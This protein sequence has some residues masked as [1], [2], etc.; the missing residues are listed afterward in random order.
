MTEKVPSLSSGR[1]T[2]TNKWVPKPKLFDWNRSR[3][4]SDF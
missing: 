3:S 2:L 4:R 1:G